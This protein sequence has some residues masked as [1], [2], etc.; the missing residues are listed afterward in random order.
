M[1]NREVQTLDHREF[2][3]LSV[4]LIENTGGLRFRSHGRSMM[5][6]I[7][8]GDILTLEKADAADLRIGD[9]VL[10]RNRTG[11]LLA[12]RIIMQRGDT[13]TTCGDALS[14]HDTPFK[15]DQLIGRVRSIEHSGKDRP[16][17]RYRSRLMAA[18]SRHSRTLPG[19]VLK[20]LLRSRC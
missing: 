17:S 13:W 9:V 10:I 15:A 5:P 19:R 12:H 6:S 16:L 20:R 11:S 1:R 2:D 18:I 3:T 8:N 14:C 7:H 4:D